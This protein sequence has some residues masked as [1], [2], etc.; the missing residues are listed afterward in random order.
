MIP[1]LVSFKNCSFKSKVPKNVYQKVDWLE[2][3]WQCKTESSSIDFYATIIK[4]V[5]IGNGVYNIQ[6]KTVKSTEYE[7]FGKFHLTRIEDKGG[8]YAAITFY[9]LI[10]PRNKSIIGFVW[11]DDGDMGYLNIMELPENL[12]FATKY[13][14]NLL[15]DFLIEN[16]ENTNLFNFYEFRRIDR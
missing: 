7:T 8:A 5:Y 13:S 6:R 2:G 9:D 3:V 10:V 1:F 16:V 14:P 12:L 15:K 11:R 4:V